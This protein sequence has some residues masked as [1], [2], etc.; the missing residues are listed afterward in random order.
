MIGF[1]HNNGMRPLLWALL[2]LFVP[3]Q[4]QGEEINT[5]QIVLGHIGDAYEWHMGTFGGWECTIPLPIIVHS[6]TSG[7][8]CFSSARL[9][10]GST[11][12]N[13]RL[14]QEGEHA[15]KVVETLASGE[16]VRPLDI[17]IT[18]N[19]CGLLLAC[20]LL[21]IA[22]LKTANW[23][24]KHPGQAPG[25][26]VGMM[27][28]VVSYIQD[29]VIKKSIGEEYRPFS[30]YL[31][32]VFFFILINNLMGI[33]P[34][35]PGGANVTGNIAVTMVLAVCTFLAVNLFGTKAYW[36]DIFWPNTP[37]F[38]KLPIPIMP[39]VEFFGIFTKPFALMIRLFA[40]IM[41]GHTIILALTC[42]I[43][44]TVSMG[45]WV[46]IGMTFVSILFCIF[47]NCLELFVACLQAYIFTLLS[48]SY[49]GLAKVKE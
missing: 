18:K 14:A 44:I 11:Y 22:V 45:V 49:I 30:S 6:P 42:L 2:L 8:H 36:K 3:L 27:E 1:N 35:F 23:Y 24:K 32:T 33:I 39:F 48:A 15:G 21:L 16:V 46:N 34:I 43:F 37:I 20:T 29:D 31:L 12:E 25:G 26:F 4:S 17:S 7:W 19:V 38:L 13:F 9:H 40:N 10:D 41:A 47:M 28:A 5:K